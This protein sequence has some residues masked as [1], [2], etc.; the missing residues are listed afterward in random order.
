MRTDRVFLSC[1]CLETSDPPF[2]GDL[3]RSRS[4][5]EGVINCD[6]A[7]VAVLREGGLDVCVS[8]AVVKIGFGSVRRWDRDEMKGRE[9]RIWFIGLITVL[10]AT[11]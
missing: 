7:W 8:L 9:N 10:Y 6:V 11:S 3:F 2:P 4:Q 5:L 1:S